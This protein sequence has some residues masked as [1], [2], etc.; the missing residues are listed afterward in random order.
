M[1]IHQSEDED[2]EKGILVSLDDFLVRCVRCLQGGGEGKG[3][4]SGG[5]EQLHPSPEPKEE[6]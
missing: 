2:G 4:T 1:K 5:N 6:S 3:K